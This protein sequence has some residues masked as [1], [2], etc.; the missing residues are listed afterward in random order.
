[1]KKFT[2]KLTLIILLTITLFS[3]F[4]SVAPV[5][6]E[7]YGANYSTSLSWMV[8]ADEI[9]GNNYTFTTTGTDVNLISI[10]FFGY[11]R[12]NPATIKALLVNSSNQIVATSYATTI[13]T[14]A[15]W[16]TFVFP[17]TIALA[18]NTN[19]SFCFIG[20]S[21]W[22]I[23]LG[24]GVDPFLGCQD[25]SNSYASPSN[26]Y[27][28]VHGSNSYAIRYTTQETPATPPTPTVPP[29]TSGDYSAIANFF[30]A[31]ALLLIPAGVL[32]WLK[33]GTWGILIGL[34]VGAGLGFIFMPA[35]V[36]LWLFVGIIIGIVGYIFKGSGGDVPQ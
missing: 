33:L 11:G 7:V 24:Y 34:L 14:S 31:L 29:S 12:Y 2:K 3:I 20:N 18:N 9:R 21:T 13:P 27:D 10:S 25:A 19:Y 1:M 16:Y 6:A 23:Y 28:M 30:V 32:Y 4:L 22:Q 35:T 5:K 8:N 26:P 15:A 17:S 36:P